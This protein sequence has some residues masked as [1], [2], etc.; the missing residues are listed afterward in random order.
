MRIT[1]MMISALAFAGAARAADD[2]SFAVRDVRLFDGRQTSVHAN[3]VAA[4]SLPAKIF[5][6][7]D[8]GRIQPGYRADLALIDGDPAQSVDATLSI[9]KIWKNGYAVDRAPPKQ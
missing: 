5:K 6:L 1:C 7:G 4:T 9:A 3:V 8:R 2:N